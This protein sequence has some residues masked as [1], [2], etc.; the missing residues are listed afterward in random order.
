MES[1]LYIHV[2]R[3][4]TCEPFITYIYIRVEVMDKTPTAIDRS[5]LNLRGNFWPSRM[6]VIISHLLL[7]ITA[8]YIGSCYFFIHIALVTRWSWTI[9]FFQIQ[10][11]DCDFGKYQFLPTLILLEP[12]F[13]SSKLT[14]Y[15]LKFH[16]ENFPS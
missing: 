9:F 12:R 16:I 5:K 2:V 1:E 6:V 3:V 11:T 4:D 8:L 15:I 10:I 14:T 7:Q 13:K